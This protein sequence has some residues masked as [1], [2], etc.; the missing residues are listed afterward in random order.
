MDDE[1]RPRVLAPVHPGLMLRSDSVESLGLTTAEAAEAMGVDAAALAEFLEGRARMGPELAVRIAKTFGATA[2]FWYAMQAAYEIETAMLAAGFSRHSRDEF[3]WRTELRELGDA[4]PHPGP[5]LRRALQSRR[6]ADGAA[7]EEIGADAGE[8]EDVFA[9]A[10]RITPSMAIGIGRVLGAAP[11]F[12]YGWQ[13]QHEIAQAVTRADEFE[14]RR[15]Y[16][17]GDPEDELDD[18]DREFDRHIMEHIYMQ[19]AAEEAGLPEMDLGEFREL[20]RNGRLSAAVAAA[21]ERGRLRFEAELAREA[22]PQPATAVAEPGE[23][24]YEEDA[25]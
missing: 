7:A 8:L 3:E 25:R 16:P 15:V 11:E 4:P 19:E 5:V 1:R 18:F 23:M 21:A 22:G 17:I 14:C 10:A 6:L 13:A 12:W 20:L 24:E 2:D 9:G